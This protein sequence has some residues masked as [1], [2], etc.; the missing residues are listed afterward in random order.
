MKNILLIVACI[1]FHNAFAL[2]LVTIAK[3]LTMLASIIGSIPN[4]I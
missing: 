4:I 1:I 3:I 2:I